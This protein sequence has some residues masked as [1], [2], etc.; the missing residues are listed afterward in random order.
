MSTLEFKFSTY[1]FTNFLEAR[2]GGRGLEKGRVDP[3]TLIC[4]YRSERLKVAIDL[5]RRW[6]NSLGF[7]GK[8]NQM[9]PCFVWRKLSLFQTK[10]SPEFKFKHNCLTTA[11]SPPTSQKILLYSPCWLILLFFIFWERGLEFRAVM[12]NISRHL[13]STPSDDGF[14]SLAHITYTRF[15]YAEIRIIRGRISKRNRRGFASCR[16]SHQQDRQDVLARSVNGVQRK[17][18]WYTHVSRFQTRNKKSFFLR[19]NTWKKL[20]S[21]RTMWKATPFGSCAQHG[22][23][24]WDIFGNRW[25]SGIHKT[26]FKLPWEEEAWKI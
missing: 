24:A 23:D 17:K 20:L 18:N 11:A 3:R 8:C 4:K 9:Q 1:Q 21:A 15:G 25:S 13:A 26:L 10:L 22:R 6:R 14:D 7:S 16:S 5:A 19:W 12:T 2:V